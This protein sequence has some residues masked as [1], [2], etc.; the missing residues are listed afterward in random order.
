MA[1]EREKVARGRTDYIDDVLVMKRKHLTRP[2]TGSIDLYQSSFE[3][4]SYLHVKGDD[5]LPSPRLEQEA[6][7][8]VRE[9]ALPAPL[10][11]CP[12]DTM[13][14]IDRVIRAC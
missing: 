10:P 5:A 3:G 6:P 1:Q 8:C 12:A 13:Q 14:C 7:A 4:R 2:Y 11:P 9:M